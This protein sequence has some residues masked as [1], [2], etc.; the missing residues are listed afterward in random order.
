MCV[1]F[2]SIYR[3]QK[4]IGTYDKEPWEKT[5]EMKILD[6]FNS[7]VALKTAK[8]KTELIDVDLVRGKIE[9]Y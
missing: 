4:K 2:L 3:Y 7:G 1:V 9:F 8:L 6:G 5:V